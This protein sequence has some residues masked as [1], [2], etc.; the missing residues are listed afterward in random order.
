MTRERERIELKLC[1]LLERINSGEE[2]LYMNPT[3]KH[4][5]AQM[6]ASGT[7]FGQAAR[8]EVPSGMVVAVWKHTPPET[9]YIDPRLSQ[10]RKV[11]EGGKEQV[12]AE[13]H[14]SSGNIVLFDESGSVLSYLLPNDEVEVIRN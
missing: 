3:S 11:A 6:F 8:S 5:Y 7:R 2:N 12:V 14:I 1:D 10:G 9:E 13:V 4:D